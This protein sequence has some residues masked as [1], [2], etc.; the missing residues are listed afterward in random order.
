[1]GTFRGSVQVGDPNGRR[2]ETVEALVDTGASYTSVP[3]PLLA[4][5]RAVAHTRD[6]FALASDEVVTWDIGQ[7]WVRAQGRTVITLVVSGEPGAAPVLGADTL[8]GV[9]P[10]PDPV[11]RRLVPVRALH[12]EARA[13]RARALATAK[14][15]AMKERS[16]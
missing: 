2:F 16:A 5:L 7:T 14:A 12:A 8:E 13:L 11:G 9:R 15:R 6:A 4:R 10:G 3:A 1:M